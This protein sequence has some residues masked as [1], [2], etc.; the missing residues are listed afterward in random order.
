MDGEGL[1]ERLRYELLRFRSEVENALRIGQPEVAG[2][3]PHA[4]CV[5]RRVC[6]RFRTIDEV[7]AHVQSPSGGLDHE[8]VSIVGWIVDQPGAGE[9][10]Q[11]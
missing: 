9:H 1:G 8:A 11:S 2:L 5:R 6:G 7:E 4:A 10:F 3:F